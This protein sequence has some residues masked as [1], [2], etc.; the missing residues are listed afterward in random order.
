MIGTSK[1]YVSEMENGK[2]FPSGDYLNRLAEELEVSIVE[3]FDDQ[4]LGDD[5]MAH[6]Q[7]MKDL[8]PEDRKAVARHA[9]GLLQKDV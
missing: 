5:I 8:L 6:I 2:K 1:S 4:E 7:V 3:L 9:L